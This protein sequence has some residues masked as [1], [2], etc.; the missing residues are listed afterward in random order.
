MSF[1]GKFGFSLLLLGGAVFVSWNCWARTRN[2]TP[3]DLPVTLHQGETI[4]SE[5]ELNYDGPY[6]I[7]IR[8][9]KTLPEEILRCLLGGN[10]D[11]TLCSARQAT[12]AATWTLQRD[13]QP[14]LSGSSVTPHSAASD[15]EGVTRVM[16]EFLGR[17]GQR[18]ALRVWFA[19][20]A[21]GLD[22]A[23]PRLTVRITG[24]ARE[25]MQAAGVLI[26]SISFICVLFG[27]MG[28][29]LACFPPKSPVPDPLGSEHRP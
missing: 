28:I 9:E 19:A 24:L 16:G 10:A 17:R 22:A 12:L 21:S 15:Q 13:G 25:N 1:Q 27:A 8:A 29:G 4:A 11:A 7:A 5:F 3:V 2:L 20:G 26:G 14:F 23:R 18:F 6:L